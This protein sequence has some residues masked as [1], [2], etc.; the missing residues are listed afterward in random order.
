MSA[1]I[2]SKRHIDAMVDFA[3]FRARGG[4]FHYSKPDAEAP[5]GFRSV[6]FSLGDGDDAAG[7][8]LWM[9]NFRS[10][11]YRYPEDAGDSLPG[12]NSFNPVEVD[13]YRFEPLR[14]TLT[15]VECLMAISGY[16]YQSCERPDWR[17]SEAYA[18]CQ[19]LRDQAI[20]CLDGYVGAGTWSIS[21]ERP[22]RQVFRI[23]AR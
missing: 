22:T 2:E 3:I 12:P 19:A 11:H 17:Q 13:G 21:D 18:F 6:K 4:V 20:S 16:E 15:P 10:V 14:D 9:E 1:Y 7:V 5:Y 8:M 23:G